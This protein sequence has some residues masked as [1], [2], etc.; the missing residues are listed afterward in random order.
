MEI[1]IKT[2]NIDE[3]TQEEH[4][5]RRV[6]DKK[7]PEKEKWKTMIV[8]GKGQCH[9]AEITREVWY[10]ER[11]EEM[12]SRARIGGKYYMINRKFY[13]LR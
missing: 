11:Q 8:I 12:K 13:I 3:T 5:G 6:N 9:G 1:I 7:N 10:L 4:R 2:M